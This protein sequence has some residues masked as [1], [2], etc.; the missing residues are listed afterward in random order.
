MGWRTWESWLTRGRRVEV[1][2]QQGPREMRKSEKAEA[3]QV[4]REVESVGD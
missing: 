2:E 3:V 4:P 1:S